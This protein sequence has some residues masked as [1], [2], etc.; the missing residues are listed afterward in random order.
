MSRHYIDSVRAFEFV[1]DDANAQQLVRSSCALAVAENALAL[2]TTA[3][4]LESFFNGD[5]ETPG[6]RSFDAFMKD[7]ADGVDGLCRPQPEVLCARQLLAY[8]YAEPTTSVADAALLVDA[9]DRVSREVFLGQQLG[10]FHADATLRLAWLR[11]TDVPSVVTAALR[12]YVQGLLDDWQTG[13]LDVQMGVVAGQYDAA[14]LALLTRQVTGD[15]ATA[16]RRQQVFEM[17]QSWRG[18]ADALALGARRWSEV[19]RGDGERADAAALVMTRTLDL[20]V[21]AG[22]A[23]DLNLRAGAGFANATFGGGLTALAND[24]EAL[25]LPFSELIHVRDADVVVTQSL[26]PA[27]TNFNLLTRRAEDARAALA[28]AETAVGAI[29]AESAE[30][31]LSSTQVRDRLNNEI[32]VVVDALIGLCG[33]PAGCTRAQVT[34]DPACRIP[35][36]LAHCGYLRPPD[37]EGQDAA[38][39]V[40]EAAAAIGAFEAA[41]SGV[42]IAESEL[43]GLTSRMELAAEGAKAFATVIEGWNARWL[44][45]VAEVE[46]LIEAREAAWT[47][48]LADLVADID[49]QNTLRGQ[50]AA[51]ATADAASWET[52]ARNGVSEDYNT[53]LMALALD[54]SG[55]GLTQLGKSMSD[56]FDLAAKALPGIA[57]TATH[58]E[59][60]GARTALTEAA[61][62]KGRVLKGASLALKGAAALAERGRERNGFYRTIELEGLREADLGAD[63][64]VEAHIAELAAT[65]ELEL[66][67]QQIAEL[68]VDRLIAALRDRAEAELAYER[69]KVELRD[70]R[71]RVL[72]LLVDVG[73]YDLNLVQAQLAATQRMLD[74]ARISERAALLAG[75]LGDLEAQRDNVVSLIGSPAV[76]FAW[77][78]RLAQAEARLERAK[79]AMMAWLVAME[80]HAVRPF[81]DQ[82]VQILLARNTVQLARIAAEMTRLTAA[83]GSNTNALSATVS[84]SRLLGYTVDRVDATDGAIYSPAVQLR[85]ALAR[86]DVPVTRQARLGGARATPAFWADP[87]VWALEFPVDIE[88]FPNLAA[89]C[90]AKVL[91]FDV[92]LIGEGLGDARPAVTLVHSGTSRLRSCQPDLNDYVAQFGPEATR[93]ADLTRLR[94]APRSISPVASVGG[95]AS[96]PEL[97][98]GNVT[99]GGLPLASDYAVIIDRAG[100]ENPDIDWDRLEDIQI[101][102]NFSFQDFFPPGDCR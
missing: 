19:L 64:T 75:R 98:R 26:D 78:N 88:T 101:R 31:E 84:L 33:L 46:R 12:D 57:G 70:R 99:L 24:A 76:V 53:S 27:D 93:F 65:A 55:A 40:S 59:S 2:G 5:G 39:N 10:A 49:A 56:R 8:A 72:G 20:Y 29:I 95:F 1:N 4:L 82:R 62:T 35:V 22:I 52:I 36:A 15:G 3:E 83:C 13:V 91:S 87:D 96:G 61:L 60:V 74:V 18:A 11:T 9:F 73:T 17:S 94:T 51:D 54:K 71:D 66:T 77:A 48:A 42:A 32:E 67:A 85:A 81:M 6:E 80:Y 102:V 97:T 7:C 69:D 47:G 25:G 21:L 23:S 16:R 43:A 44:D 92:A 86:A 45:S 34:T 30:R 37:A 68:Q 79:S 63:L 58:A 41:V 100:G 50:L 89:S 38:T 14:G 28:D 90:N